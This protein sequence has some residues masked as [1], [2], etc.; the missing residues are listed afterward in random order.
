MIDIKRIL[1]FALAGTVAFVV[2]AGVLVLT[3]PFVGAFWGRVISFLA[4]VTTTWLINRNL[5]FKD[6]D[7]GVGL[8]Q[9]FARYGLAMLPGAGANWLAYGIVASLVA[10]SALGLTLAVAAGSL[11]GL[12]VNFL[13]ADKLIY[14]KSR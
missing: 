6:R 5:T 9:E 4:G 1:P 13:A 2:D 7:A 10:Q 11:S 12:A 8:G 3:A 14:K